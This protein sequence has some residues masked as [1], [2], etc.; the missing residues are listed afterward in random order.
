MFCFSSQCATIDNFSSSCSRFK[1]LQ[2]DNLV[3]FL[4]SNELLPIFYE[5]FTENLFE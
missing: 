5:E 3:L 1:M 4:E 2:T